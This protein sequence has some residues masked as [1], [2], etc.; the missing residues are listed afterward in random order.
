MSTSCKGPASIALVLHLQDTS[1][2]LDE[3]PPGQFA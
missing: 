3:V 1:L 2:G